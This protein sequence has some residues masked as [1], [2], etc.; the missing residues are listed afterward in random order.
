MAEAR[1]VAG[2]IGPTN[3][4]LSLS[5]DVNDPGFARSI[6][7][8]SRTNIASRCAALIE[9]G[10]DFIL[11]ETVLRH[12]ERQGRQIMAARRQKRAIW[13]RSVPLMMS[14]THH[15]YVR[16]QPVGHTVEAFWYSVRHLKPLTIGAQLRVRGGPAAPASSRTLS[17]LADTLIMVYP[18]AGLPNELGA[19]DE[20]PEQTAELSRNGPRRAGQHGRRLLRH[21]ARAYRR[22][23]EGGG[24]RCPA[25][26]T[27]AP[28]H[29]PP[30]GPRTDAYGGMNPPPSC[31]RRL[32]SMPPWRP[33]TGDMEPSLDE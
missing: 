2:A 12:A 23:C 7:I 26:R 18:N 27:D 11:I 6:S 32:A 4:T 19:Y 5:P 25:R 29:H 24:R 30:C 13:P 8:R 15:R 21:H 17:K 31:Q 20:L 33:I 22:D 14:M 3:K 16:P 28:R 1:F 10:V 9:G